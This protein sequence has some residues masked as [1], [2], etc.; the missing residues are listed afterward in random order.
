MPNSLIPVLKWGGI[1]LAVV[2]AIALVL[3]SGSQPAADGN[4]A[5]DGAPTVLYWILL[6]IGVVAAIVGFAKGGRKSKA[7]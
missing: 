7:E 4:G 5:Q 2:F 6:V 1:A 3:A